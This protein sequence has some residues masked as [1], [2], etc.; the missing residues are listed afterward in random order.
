MTNTSPPNDRLS[1]RSLV[2]GCM[3]GGAA[4]IASGAS[5]AAMAPSPVKVSKDSV[6]YETAAATN[7]HRCGACKL[8]LAPSS[9][10]AV[11]GSV[12]ADCS[13]RIWLPKQA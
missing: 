7:G 12:N 1:R 10:V 3:A 4:A 6:H 9:C 13:C 8:F 2:L 5:S 11:A